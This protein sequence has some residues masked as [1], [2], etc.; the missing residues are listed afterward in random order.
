VPHPPPASSSRGGEAIARS[1]GS[2]S[3]RRAA[4][5][6]A[7][8]ENFDTATA[9]SI[10]GLLATV[11]GFPSAFLT[12]VCHCLPQAVHLLP[13]TPHTACG[14]QWHTVYIRALVVR[15]AARI[16]R[17]R[18]VFRTWHGKC[19]CL[20]DWVHGARRAGRRRPPACCRGGVFR[21]KWI[22]FSPHAC[23]GETDMSCPR[24]QDN[25]KRLR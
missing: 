21:R 12:T 2:P 20:S 23:F 19:L 1:T 9:M 18:E 7:R 24:R 14:K 25:R 13:V 8:G 15:N 6:R 11:R 10:S 5:F 17:N 22:S 4:G 3:D 16:S